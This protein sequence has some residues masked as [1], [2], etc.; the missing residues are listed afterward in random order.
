MPDCD[1][2]VVGAGNAA[3]AAAVSAREQGAGR[4]VVLEKATEALR[5]GNTHYSGGL[6]RFAYDRAED[7]LPLVPDVER[8]MPDFVSTV[9]PYPVAQFRA[10]LHRVT[11]G[12][13]DPELSE[14]LLTRSF[15]TVRW[16][17]AQGVPLEAAVSLSAVKVG[18]KTRWSPG[19]IIRARHEG[20]GLSRAWFEIAAS[21]GVEIRYET[22]A[23]QLL[24]DRRGRITGV[25]VR[26]R[27]G[28]QE[29][30]ATAVVLG[31][32]GFES[33]PEWRARYLGRP[34]DHAKVRGTRYNTGDG[35]RMAI[36]A[37]AL[38]YGQWTGCH[39]TP[40]DA[41]A[42]PFGDR[43]LTDKSN[44]LSYPYGVLVNRLGRR[45]FD[46]GE[47]F[48]F[49]TYAKLGGII[50][51]EP[52]GIGWQ[53][54]DSKVTHLLEGRYQTGAPLTADSLEA[55]VD[56][57]P[58]DRAAGRRTLEAYNAA[59]TAGRFDPT[60]RDG[61]A[62]R[63]L[64]LAKSNWAQRLDTPP[65]LAYPVTGGITFTFGGV[66]VNDRAQVMSTS[67]AVI[68]GLYAC[69]EMVGGLFHGNYPG[70]TGLMSGAVF[71]RL[72]GAQ[73]AGE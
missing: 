51:N 13:T 58:L 40:I 5:G 22:G 8:Q 68:P 27:E 34:W 18:G 52:G 48:Q 49:Y 4:V 73:A 16:V 15:D 69:G 44:R 64:P 36:D 1:V 11:E 25:G 29:V 50:L 57:L 20:V 7:L 72:A 12:R 38:P 23:V 54:F 42:P 59:V 31:C 39:S 19:A 71:G 46:E 65:F 62:T 2:L 53:I 28:Y 35:L 63:G 45:F 37:G 60:V 14:I 26:D 10:D 67:W 6:F 17:A 3:L 9:E 21:R 66:R 55:L 24:Q 33:N 56:K 47:D 32:G 41:D 70:G 43:K 61:L 30:S